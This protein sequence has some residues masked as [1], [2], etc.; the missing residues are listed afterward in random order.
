MKGWSLRSN[1]GYINTG[2]AMQYDM[3]KSVFIPGTYASYYYQYNKYHGPHDM[4]L[5]F[6]P[7]AGYII[8][9]GGRDDIGT[10]IITGVY[11]PRTL[12]MGLEKQYQIG[13]GNPS[14]N[15]GHIVIIQVEW[16]FQNRQFEGKYYLRTKKHRDENMF[17][18]RFEGSKN[19]RPYTIE[20]HV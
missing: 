20:S 13:T 9:G 7:E 16:N 6:Y 10:Y 1:N 19:G 2:I 17:I 11:S 3:S 12:R 18:I 15:L 8:H 14:E 4:K 5:A